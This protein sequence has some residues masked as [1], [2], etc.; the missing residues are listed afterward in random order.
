MR[1]NRNMSLVYKQ[2]GL[3][4]SGILGNLLARVA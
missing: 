4:S 2:I 3:L 1:H